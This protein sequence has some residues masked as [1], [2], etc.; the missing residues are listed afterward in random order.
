[1]DDASD[2]S[3]GHPGARR[4]AQSLRVAASRLAGLA[5]T[6]RREGLASALQAALARL[7]RRAGGASREDTAALR[8][9][10]R[11]LESELRRARTQLER[12][13]DSL[14]ALALEQAAAYAAAPEPEP[15]PLVSVVM[16]V[17][18]GATSLRAAVESVRRQRYPSWELLVVDDGSSDATPALLDELAVDPRI[19]VLR[20]EPRGVSGARNRALAAARG[21]IVAYL[22]ADNTWFPH[23]LELV[24]S[25]L[26]SHPDRGAVYVS[27]LVEDDARGAAVRFEPFDRARLAE[28]NTIDLNVFAH[29]RELYEKYG[30][31]DEG[32]TRLVDWDLIARY[33]EDRDPVAVPAIGALYRAHGG[34]RISTREP[35]WHARDT[36]QRRLERPVRPGLRVLYLLMHY[37]Q[38]TES[39]MRWE[40]EYMRRRGVQVEVWTELPDAPAPFQ[41]DVRIHRGPIEDA[42]ASLRPH[43]A[44]VHWLNV[45]ARVRDAVARAGLPLTVRGHSFEFKRKTIERL[46]A[47]PVVRRIYLYPRFISELAS[48]DKVSPLST[49][50]PGHLYPP[51]REKDTRLVLRCGA[52]LPAKDFETFFAVAERC[53]EHRFVLVVGR[54]TGHEGYADELVALNRARGSPVEIHVNLQTEE[55][56]PLVARAGIFLHTFGADCDFGQPTGICEAMATGA[57]VIARRSAGTRA[58]LGDVGAFYD[59][60]D[61]AA[62]RIQKS[63][64]WSE[65]RWQAARRAASERAFQRHADTRVLPRVLEDWLAIRRGRVMHDDS[66]EPLDARF[67]PLVDYLF[68]RGQDAQP[69]HDG[70]LTAHQIGVGRGLV[71][72]GAELDV[73]LAG[74]AHSFYGTERVMGVGYYLERRGELRAVI[75][76]RAERLVY[77]NCAM[78]RESLD[79]AL[80]AGRGPRRLR[81]RFTGGELVLDEADFDDLC[82][83]HLCDWLEQVARCGRWSERRAAY[84]KLA[85]HLGGRARADFERVYALE[86]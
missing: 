28:R 63:L 82:R 15:G 4:R 9:E 65:D 81:D 46:Q 8:R 41:T 54:A 80:A 44:H 24:V 6:A 5:G 86:G 78:E 75:G 10:V 39:Y 59:D 1:M 19:R 67:R 40:I 79:A 77:A 62:A 34:D 50:F 72:W 74:M 43:L 22:D 76:E 14:R 49:P 7:H 38:L 23:H 58:L 61:E 17:R 60:A 53:P 20:Q 3:R 64:T 11:A 25:A 68:S 71:A 69:H 42:I 12:Q 32:L 16:P 83:V 26:A 84:R 70:A 33:C 56:A 2:G 55:I 57:Y 37:P 35:F 66:T 13:S 73:C 27:Q 21:A 29:R 51:A 85:E 45:V 36:V 30:G 48:T 52:A 31:F 18:D 47:D